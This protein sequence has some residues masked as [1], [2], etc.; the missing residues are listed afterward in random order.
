[1]I[2]LWS[3]SSLSGQVFNYICIISRG[4]RAL[5]GSYSIIKYHMPVC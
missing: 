1:M 2:L 4:F 5:I 3:L